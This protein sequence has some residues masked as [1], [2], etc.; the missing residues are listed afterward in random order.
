V[1]QAQDTVSKSFITDLYLTGMKKAE[2]RTLKEILIATP[3]GIVVDLVSRSPSATGD[4]EVFACGLKPF[5]S[6]SVAAE[7]E[8]GLAKLKKRIGEVGLHLLV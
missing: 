1:F 3:S 7:E 4:D 6:M 5:V 2:F 8:R